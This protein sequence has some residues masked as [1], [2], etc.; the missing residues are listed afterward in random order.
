MGTKGPKM[1]LTANQA[2]A[3]WWLYRQGPFN[4]ENILSVPVKPFK[5]QMKLPSLVE[6]SVS[7]Q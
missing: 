2:A 1:G 6:Y 7:F 4:S 3:I 5:S